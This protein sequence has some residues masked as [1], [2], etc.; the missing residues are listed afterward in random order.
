V[1][2]TISARADGAVYIGREAV[3]LIKICTGAVPEVP[4]L[5]TLRFS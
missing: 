4:Y 5:I 3:F 1:K 2:C